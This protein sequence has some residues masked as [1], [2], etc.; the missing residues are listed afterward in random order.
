MSKLL[1]LGLFR[2][3]L[4]VW[5]FAKHLVALQALSCGEKLRSIL[6]LKKLVF[7]KL[8]ARVQSRYDDYGTIQALNT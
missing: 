2:D 5:R 3:N 6:L 7:V 8:R 1:I 4:G